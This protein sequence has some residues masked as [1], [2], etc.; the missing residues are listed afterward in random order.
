MEEFD[1]LCKGCMKELNGKMICD[2]CGC[3]QNFEQ[4]FPYLEV[5]QMLEQRYLV[6]KKIHRDDVEIGYIAYDMV[7]KTRVYIK[8]L[9]PNNLC[10]RDDKSPQVTVFN[11][12]RSQFSLLMDEFLNYFRTAAKLRSLAALIPIFNIFTENN[13]AYVVLEFQDGITLEE[14]VNNNGGHISWDTARPLFMPVLSALNEMN[15]LGINDLSLCPK[16][17]IIN[18]EHKMKIMAMSVAK[19]SIR[20]HVIKNNL[21]D[22]FA[23][24]EQ[25]EPSYEVSQATDVYG[26]TACLFYALTGTKPKSA[27][28]RKID[29]RLFIQTDILKT[30]PQNVV[31]ALADGLQVYK[32]K[33]IQSFESL[34][35]QLSDIKVLKQEAQNYISDDQ[36]SNDDENYDMRKTNFTL[37]I[38][39]CVVAFLVL[40]AM[41]SFW[42]FGGNLNMASEKSDSSSLASQVPSDVSS[43]ETNEESE[44]ARIIVPDIVGKNYQDVNSQAQSIGDYQI[45]IMSEEFNDTVEQGCIITQTPKPGDKIDKGSA[46]VV[47]VSK[48]LKERQLPQIAGLSLSDASVKLSQA[49]FIPIQTQSYSDT[50]KEGNV[51]GYYDRKPFDK[52]EYG[53]EV[54]IVV[55]KGPM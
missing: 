52:L 53:S 29:D 6:G 48:G 15:S 3:D 37:L 47:T 28:K 43:K 21:H 46:I 22:G 18:N 13:T 55:S 1:K 33:R 30:I 10:E 2:Y 26:F 25:Y 23:A 9:Y 12:T 27:L 4:G 38:I 54:K 36:D 41:G 24:L 45:L 5:G 31:S 39:S 11:S 8:E 19:V 17:L 51:I 40:V 7:M 16:N 14:F 49:G 44:S 34:R 50:I 35:D 20:N 42:L 32:Q